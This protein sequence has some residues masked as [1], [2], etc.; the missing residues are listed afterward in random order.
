MKKYVLIATSEETLNS[1]TGDNTNM[2]L[3]TVERA[4]PPENLNDFAGGEASIWYGYAAQGEDFAVLVVDEVSPNKV[5]LRSKMTQGLWELE[6]K[7]YLDE[8]LTL[9]RNGFHRFKVVK[10]E[11]L[12][13]RK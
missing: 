11:S 4:S 3:T 9:K 13:P 6:G 12:A 10:S 1:P 5:A 7:I 8:W 2:R